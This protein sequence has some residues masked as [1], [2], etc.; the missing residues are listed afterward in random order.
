[1][2][3]IS[4][5]TFKNRYAPSIWSVRDGVKGWAVQTV[6]PTL[7]HHG[8]RDCIQEY[9][10]GLSFAH[11][12]EAEKPKQMA[13][14]LILKEWGAKWAEDKKFV[15]YLYSGTNNYMDVLYV[16]WKDKNEPN[17]ID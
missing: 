2:D 9:D 13:E 4:Y 6:T 12:K 15:Y 3:I 16:Y 10:Y 17:I 8:W 5:K 1:M 7:R 14:R 11:N